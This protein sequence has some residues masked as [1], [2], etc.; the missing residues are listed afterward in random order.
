MLMVASVESAHNVGSFKVLQ[1]KHNISMYETVQSINWSSVKP[2]FIKSKFL[3]DITGTVAFV[4][5]S[6][7]PKNRLDSGI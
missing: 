7:S 1:L 2:Y 3:L 4:I 5:D 6:E